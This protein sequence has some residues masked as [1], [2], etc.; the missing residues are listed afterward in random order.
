MD[1]WPMKTYFDLEND[2]ETCCW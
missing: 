2:F 1:M